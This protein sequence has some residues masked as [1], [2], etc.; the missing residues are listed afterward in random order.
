M[1]CMLGGIFA[2][3][4][5]SYSVAGR[6]GLSTLGASPHPAL[7]FVNPSLRK[8]AFKT[9]IMS[10]QGGRDS[11]ARCNSK[12]ATHCNVWAFFNNG[13]LDQGE[14]HFR[15]TRDDGT[16]TRCALRAATVLSL[17]DAPE[18]FKSRYV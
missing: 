4:W 12:F 8:D 2:L 16:V 11:K 10:A 15:V 3:R 9:K 14:Q 13:D 6:G 1:F 5:L 17:G 7:Q 18:Q